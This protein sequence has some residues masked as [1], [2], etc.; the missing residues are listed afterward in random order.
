[1]Y[2]KRQYFGLGI[3]IGSLFLYI[4]TLGKKAIQSC[5]YDIVPRPCTVNEGCV[6]FAAV[7]HVVFFLSGACAHCAVV[8]HEV[9]Y[10]F[11]ISDAKAVL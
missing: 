4:G 6:A 10:Y 1:M 11:F 8:G 7:E 5:D 3:H 9:F 2:V